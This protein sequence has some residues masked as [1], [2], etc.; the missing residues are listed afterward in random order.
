MV[1]HINVI[2]CWKNVGPNFPN[3]NVGKQIYFLFAKILLFLHSLFCLWVWPPITLIRILEIKIRYFML[4]IFHY[5]SSHEAE[6]VSKILSS[7][8]FYKFNLSYSARYDKLNFWTRKSR[9]FRVCFVTVV[10]F[11]SK[12]CNILFEFLGY[13]TARSLGMPKINHFPT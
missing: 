11:G 9:N 6:T 8:F 7:I 1:K 12:I 4:K 10:Y 2:H 5:E 13:V 3:T